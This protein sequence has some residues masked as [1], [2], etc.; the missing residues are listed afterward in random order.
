[1][2][3]LRLSV[4]NVVLCN[5]KFCLF[6][7]K[8]APKLK[9]PKP[10]TENVDPNGQKEPKRKDDAKKAP[11]AGLLMRENHQAANSL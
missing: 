5:L 3:E 8:L 9:E 6:R 10:K 7:F 1:M 2:S 11:K 4:L